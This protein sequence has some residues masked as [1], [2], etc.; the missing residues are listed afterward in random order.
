[1]AAVEGESLQQ[2]VEHVQG[3]KNIDD[4]GLNGFEKEFSVGYFGA[5]INYRSFVKA[6]VWIGLRWWGQDPNT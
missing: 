1:M 3:L 4:E 5:V 6:M 2:F